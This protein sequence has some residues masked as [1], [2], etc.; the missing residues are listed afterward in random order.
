M[1]VS[2]LPLDAVASKQMTPS[3][4]APAKALAIGPQLPYDGSMSDTIV[5][6]ND[7]QSRYEAHIDGEFAGFADFRRDGDIVVMPHTEVF[8]A[9]GGKGVGSALARSA[10][11]DIASQNLTVRPDCTFIRGWLDKHPDHPVNVI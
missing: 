1:I 11:D 9:F 2:T 6:K 3:V 7:Q 8:D 5:T 10:L 4:K